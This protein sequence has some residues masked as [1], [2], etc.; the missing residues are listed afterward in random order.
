MSPRRLPPTYTCDGNSAPAA[1]E[2]ASH[3]FALRI[4]CGRIA[5]PGQIVSSTG[6]AGAAALPFCL[7]RAALLALRL[8]T[9]ADSARIR[10]DSVREAEMRGSRARMR[11]PLRPR[12]PLLYAS[13]YF[14]FRLAALTILCAREMLYRATISAISYADLM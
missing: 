12:A 10:Q 3:S 2:A 9:A 5:G 8:A 14:F 4:I 11:L 1:V 13:V 7:S 6:V